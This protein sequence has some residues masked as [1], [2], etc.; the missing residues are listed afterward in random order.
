MKTR[1]SQTREPRC[2]DVTNAG[3]ETRVLVRTREERRSEH[4]LRVTLTQ[5]REDR[6]KELLVR[7]GEPRLAIE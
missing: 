2:G 3:F 5:E 6:I 1:E 4:E 7:G